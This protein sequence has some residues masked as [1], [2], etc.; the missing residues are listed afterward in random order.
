MGVGNIKN[1]LT[2]HNIIL[3]AAAVISGLVNGFIGTGGGIIL[4]FVLKFRQK[5]KNIADG[6]Q[7][8]DSVMK[9]ILATTVSA[10]IPMSAVSSIVYMLKGSVMYKELLT[11]LPAALIGGIA[12]AFLLDKLKFTIVK[13]I[14]AGMIIYAGIRMIFS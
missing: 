5:R 3:S 7:N 9:D 6:S 2:K 12:G 1:I 8:A 13:K 4:Y 14:F 10:V 11:Y